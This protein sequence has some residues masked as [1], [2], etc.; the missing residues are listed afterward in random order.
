[1]ATRGSI[2]LNIENHFPKREIEKG[3]SGKIDTARMK[4]VAPKNPVHGF[5]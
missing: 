5:Q 3:S 4:R 2:F 1:M